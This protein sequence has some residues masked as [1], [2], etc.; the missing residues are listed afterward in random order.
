[1]SVFSTKLALSEKLKRSFERKLKFLR[2]QKYAFYENRKL[3][4]NK[5]NIMKKSETSEKTK[6]TTYLKFHRKEMI[7]LAPF[8]TTSGDENLPPQ[9]FWMGSD[10][11]I[12]SKSIH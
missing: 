7:K 12:W 8:V 2:N 9:G 5:N 11:C 3:Q 10:L 6:N 4:K 1:M